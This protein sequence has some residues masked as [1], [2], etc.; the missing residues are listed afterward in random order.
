MKSQETSMSALLS[1]QD[2]TY[3][4]THG[5]L[6]PSYRLEPEVLS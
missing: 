3:Y 6:V 4:Q 1:S 5:C 2:L